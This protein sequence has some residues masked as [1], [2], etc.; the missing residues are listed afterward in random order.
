MSD[1]DTVSRSRI[2]D[3]LPPSYLK[4]SWRGSRA[5]S[6]FF[7]VF[8]AFTLTRQKDIENTPETPYGAFALFFGL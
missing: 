7:N 6:H 4:A 1:V 2:D 5:N 8:V 3:W